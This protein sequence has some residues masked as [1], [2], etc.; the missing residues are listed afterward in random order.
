M[1][2]SDSQVRKGDELKAVVQHIVDWESISNWRLHLARG[3]V[4]YLCFARDVS[5]LEVR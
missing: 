5:L 4:T 1:V 2:L 3:N